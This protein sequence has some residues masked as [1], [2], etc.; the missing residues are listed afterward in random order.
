MRESHA[1]SATKRNRP[2]L[3]MTR[4]SLALRACGRAAMAKTTESLSN[5]T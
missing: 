1:G 2:S 3:A 5:D 4:P